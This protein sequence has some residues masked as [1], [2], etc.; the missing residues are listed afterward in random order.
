M[1]LPGSQ[2][3][4][5]VDVAYFLHTYRWIFR[6]VFV[7]CLVIGARSA[8][9]TQRAVGRIAMVLSL[10]IV[11]VVLYMFNFRMQAD[12]MFLQTN[13]L[14]LLSR[15][16]N[17]I[18]EEKLVLGYT[19][20]N[21]A[22]AYP[23]Q[24]IAY[25]HQVLDTVCGEQIMVTY[26]SVCRTGR[27]YKPQIEGAPASFRLVGMDHF[28]A[29]FEDNLTGSWWMQETGVA[30]TGD[31]KG[32]ALPELLSEQMSLSQWLSFYPNSLIM[33]CDTIFQDEY[34]SLDTY[35]SGIGRGKLT[36]TDTLS[37]KDKSWVIGVEL[38]NESKAYDWND[39]KRQRIIHDNVGKIPI[40]IL[41]AND[42]Q[43]FFAFERPS[44][45]VQFTFQND[46]LLFQD[47]RYDLTGKPLSPGAPS[48]KKIQAYQEFWHSWRT[49][50]NTPH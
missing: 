39:L 8:F 41:L 50:R 27:I 18:P 24:L 33:Q 42:N 46:T 21:E 20:E 7:L 23:I 16:Q 48:L 4:N 17:E 6:A 28:N 34:D 9:R 29:M 12:R 3:I 19:C 5:T 26:C 31:S 1:P 40:V 36:G 47:H 13:S 32:K 49:F 15:E 44:A 43:S 11:V 35:D 38:N 14:L 10:V 25:H 45:E 37:W 30:V 22:R 2:K